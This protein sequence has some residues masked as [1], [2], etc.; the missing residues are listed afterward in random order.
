[1]ANGG[2]D[3]DFIV[4]DAT[5]SHLP[6][7]VAIFNHAVR[8]TFAIWSETETT[9]DQRRAWMAY[10]RSLGFPVIVAVSPDRSD[11]VLGYGSYGIFRDFPG[12]VNTVE[13]SV[14]VTPAAQR[15]GIG[16]AI[17]SELIRRARLQHLA[18]MVG[19]IDAQNA[20]SIAMHAGLGFER[21]GCLA[22]VGRKF[23]KS[24]DLV[25]MVKAL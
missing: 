5:E 11:E 8:E 1:M 25:F 6:G 18:V 17:V 14:Y 9:L 20:G 16:K 12:Y 10:R 23:G 21:Q 13:H 2:E 19:G 15:R 24:L 22:G 4:V 3:G 7:I